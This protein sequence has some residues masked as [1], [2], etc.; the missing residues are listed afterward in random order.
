MPTLYELILLEDNNETLN[1]INLDGDVL[2][3][4]T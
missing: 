1:L 4:Q 2:D 3:L